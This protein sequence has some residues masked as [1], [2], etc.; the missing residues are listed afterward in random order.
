MKYA[1]LL[2]LATPLALLAQAAQGDPF[3]GT[4]K[5]D[6][7]KSKF[8]PGPPLTSQ[9]VT[10]RSDGKV[11]VEG[12]A[13]N[14][15]VES[16]SYTYAPGTQAQITGMEDSSVLEKRSGNTLEHAWKFGAESFKGKGV[17]SSDGR[18][19]TYTMDG[20]DNQGRHEH[21]ILIYDRAAES[22]STAAAGTWKLN[23][24]KSEFS[25]GPAPAS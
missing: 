11:S 22:D 17:L 21:D 13:S 19:M 20:I 16:W 3:I 23:V 12:T 25:P 10:I 7:A 9:T 8:D 6:T 18:I 1:L 24:A 2:V 14:G 5:L 15:N 4:W